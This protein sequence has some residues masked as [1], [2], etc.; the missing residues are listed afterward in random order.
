MSRNFSFFSSFV[1]ITIFVI[2]FFSFFCFFVLTKCLLYYQS[3]KPTS[4]NVSIKVFIA[5]LFFEDT[6]EAES[7]ICI[8]LERGKRR[9]LASYAGGERMGLVLTVIEQTESFL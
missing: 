7:Y 3:S 8:L 5:K 1:K 2:L 9:K 6:C 4:L